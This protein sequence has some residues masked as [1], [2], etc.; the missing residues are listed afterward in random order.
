[1]S[2]TNTDVTTTEKDDASK[3]SI[4]VKIVNS[5]LETETEPKQELKKESESEYIGDVDDVDEAKEYSEKVQKR[6][7]K[8]RW[9]KGEEQR[10]KKSAVA[11]QE[12]AIL[13]ARGVSNENARLK[14]IVEHGEKA[15]IDNV[16]G[17]IAANINQAKNDAK[18]AHMEGDA[19]KIVAAQEAMAKAISE[20]DR[21]SSYRPVQLIPTP[22]FN[23]QARA[24]APVRD[25]KAE[26]W[27][28]KNTWFGKDEEMTGLAYGTHEKLV[29]SGVDP[30]SSEYYEAIDKSIRRYFP[31]KFEKDTQSGE[32]RQSP[33]RT[34]VVAP[35]VRTSGKQR[36]VTLT[37]SQV[38]LAKRLGLT[39]EQYA[40]QIAKEF[41]NG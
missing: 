11:L 16:R 23:P 34:S 28:S 21:I 19:D 32:S 20:Q 37:E 2:D 33:S 40:S 30:R 31:D 29:R 7:R 6:I 12:E 36:I 17:R 9:E 5:E 1:M 25:E 18:A 10:A 14:S 15:L 8:L 41:S 39:K 38:S 26:E 22:E 27:A 4:E 35:V 24:A 3:E 13:Y